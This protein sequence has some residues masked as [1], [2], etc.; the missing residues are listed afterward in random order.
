MK[1]KNILIAF[2]MIIGTTLMAQEKYEQAVLKQ[3][4]TIGKIWKSVEGQEFEEI[5]FNA[6][7]GDYTPVLQEISKMKD[8]GW[9]VWNSSMT[10]NGPT[11]FLR[12]K[13][14]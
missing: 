1:L 14:K 10:D 13:L 4:S 12:R 7:I 8:Q 5:K 3:L 11:Y 2:M 6:N 9:E